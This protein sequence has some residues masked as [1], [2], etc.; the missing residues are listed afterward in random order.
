MDMLHNIEEKVT[1]TNIKVIVNKIKLYK[2]F[3]IQMINQY[4]RLMN[5]HGKLKF[6]FVGQKSHCRKLS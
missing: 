6:S 3:N 4:M 2:M 1:G 5:I